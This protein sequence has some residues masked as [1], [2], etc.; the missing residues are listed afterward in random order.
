MTNEDHIAQWLIDVKEFEEVCEMAQE[1]D[2]S[3]AWQFINAA[4]AIMEKMKPR[5]LVVECAGGLVQDV[6]G[7][8]PGDTYELVDWDEL[9]DSDDREGRE[10]QF[11][12]SIAVAKLQS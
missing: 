3:D 7:M 9:E 12:N 11:N 1:T 5:V 4:K 10:I 8:R 6:H 2:P